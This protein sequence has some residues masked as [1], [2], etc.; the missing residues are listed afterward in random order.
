MRYRRRAMTAAPTLD[1]V[2]ATLHRLFIEAPDASLRKEDEQKCR[3]LTGVLAQLARMKKD[4]HLV[5]AAAGKSSVG[6]VAAELL[7][8]GR[9]TIVER[10][11]A[12]I[13]AC[14][15]AAGRLQRDVAVEVRELDLADSAALPEEADAIV[16]LHA[17][18]GAADLV[19]DGAIRS[20]ARHAFVAPCCYGE[21]VPFRAHAARVVRNMPYAADDVIRRRITASLVDMERKLRLEAAGF[22]TEIEEFV[23]P[24]VTPHNLVFCA[25]QTRSQVRVARAQARLAA[26]RAAA[27]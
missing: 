4:A 18:G 8:I 25:R 24:T 27:T 3:E 15:A 22:E 6:L 12:R 9:L 26:L 16:A 14:R 20:R 21:T 19:I 7:P 2:R 10:D 13:A 1:D 5:D 23:A 11:P 17:C